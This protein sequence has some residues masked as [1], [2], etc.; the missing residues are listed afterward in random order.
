MIVKTTDLIRSMKWPARIA[1][2]TIAGLCLI[3]I[4][5]PFVAPYAY[6]LQNVDNS[7]AAP[8]GH[9]WF[10]TDALGRDLFSRLVYGCR[11]SLSIA[12][13]TAF[14]S[15]IIG[16]VWGT[17]AGYIGGWVDNVMMRIVDILYT[18]PSLIVMILVMLIFGRDLSGI[19]IALTVTGWLGAARIMRAQILSWKNR[20]FIEAAHSIGVPDW[21]IVVR[22]LLPNCAAPIIVE[23]SYIIPTNILAEAFLSFL[24]IGIRPPT[25]S[26]GILAEEGWRSLRIYPHLTLFPGA[27]IFMTMLSFNL[28]GDDLRDRMDPFL[29]GK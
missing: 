18:L 12:F 19:F 27:L 25:P 24:G 15:L 2:F 3:A 17:L 6:D 5:A 10:G 16:T 29:K 26:W 9:H 4:L 23:L 22:H 14:T 7:Y 11:I 28:L 1:L 21:K 13:L 20:P 8:S